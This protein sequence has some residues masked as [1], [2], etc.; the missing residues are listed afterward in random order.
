MIF[1]LVFWLLLLGALAI[2]WQA[3]DRQDR[4]VLVTIG[5]AA[6]LSAIVHLAFLDWRT[7]A[8][9][10]VAAI[11]LVLLAILVRYA[12]T[13]NRHWPIWFAAF[14][15]TATLIAVAAPFFPANLRMMVGMISGFWAIP[16]LV[17][18]V[19]G[20]LNDQR[21]GIANSPDRTGQ[22]DNR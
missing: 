7:L 4:K 13:S 8:L 9:A 22:G 6:A 18:M 3:G 10:L 2:G 14:H 5:C 1:P 15:A 20:L 21:A 16:A 11:D 19:V 17:T 12:L